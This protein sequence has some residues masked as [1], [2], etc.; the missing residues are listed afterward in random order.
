MF[1]SRTL[2]ES[3]PNTGRKTT[4]TGGSRLS[5]ADRGEGEADWA[6]RGKWAGR[7]SWAGVEKKKKGRGREREVLGWAGKRKERVKGFVF[8]FLGIRSNEFNSNLN[9]REFK[10][11][12]NN[13]Q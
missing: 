6:K 1:V 5:V 3:V 9:S 12:L 7:A 4:P 2:L 8:F 10:L 11:E 13:K